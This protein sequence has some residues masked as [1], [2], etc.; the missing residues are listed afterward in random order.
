MPV[1]DTERQPVICVRLVSGSTEYEQGAPVLNKTPDTRGRS[2]ERWQEV[3]ISR[4][5]KSSRDDQAVEHRPVKR[6][7]KHV[8][9]DRFAADPAVLDEAVEML[10]RCP[11]EPG[12]AAHPLIT[13]TGESRATSLDM[14]VSWTT[15]TTSP[16]GL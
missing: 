1:Y 6:G 14:P 4:V 8:G 9:S 10:R 7:G 11:D 13:P 2:P 3:R 15:F 16:L 12:T 5:G